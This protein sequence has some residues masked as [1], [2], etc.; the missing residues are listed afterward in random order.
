MA[1]RGPD[2]I[3][4]VRVF[5]RSRGRGQDRRRQRGVVDEEHREPDAENG[6]TRLARRPAR[7]GAA[8]HLGR[9]RHRR[10]GGKT[11]TMGFWF[12][13]Y[14][15]SLSGMYINPSPCVWLK[16]FQNSLGASFA[17]PSTPLTWRTLKS[18]LCS[19]VLL[20]I[21][22]ATK[23]RQSLWDGF[24]CGGFYGDVLES[25]TRP[26]FPLLECLRN[27]KSALGSKAYR[28]HVCMSQ[29]RREV[30]KTNGHPVSL[31][32]PV[33]PELHP[34]PPPLRCSLNFRSHTTLR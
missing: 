10:L 26:L 3:S 6:V 2:L 22:F 27:E 14:W 30:P 25:E 5:R 4:R 31:P 8:L 19:F 15:F 20:T 13:L 7:G 34:K 9:R 32:S 33:T 11:C 21:V 29:T 23:K 1:P 28:Q 24:L 18:G 17:A 12:G 16:I